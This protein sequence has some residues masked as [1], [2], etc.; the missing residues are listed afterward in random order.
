M[1]YCNHCGSNIRNAKFC[2]QC[3]KPAIV[4]TE[5]ATSV[6]A[7]IVP[8]FQW[9]SLG[10]WNWKR[11]L[12][13]IGIVVVC[14]IFYT[15]GS[16]SADPKKVVENFERAVKENN[17]ALM[18]EQLTL[19]EQIEDKSVLTE[20]VAKAILADIQSN[21]MLEMYK[22]DF[23]QSA[24]NLHDKPD[25]TLKHDKQREAA[26]LTF[27]KDGHKWLFFDNYKILISPAY[28]TLRVPNKV[29]LETK[30]KG[31]QIESMIE[32]SSE[33]QKNYII[34]PLLPGKH[35]LVARFTSDLF[36]D[37]T[38]DT[39]FEVKLRMYPD[40]PLH[41][42]TK[43]VEI[44]VD[45]NETKLYYKDKQIPVQY[46]ESWNGFRAELD[47]VPTMPISLTYK[48]V[49]P[50]GEITHEQTLGEQ[51]RLLQCPASLAEAPEFK[52]VVGDL[53]R[54]YNLAWVIYA[55]SKSNLDGLK[56]FLTPNSPTLNQYT[57]EIAQPAS[58]VFV[59][60]LTNLAIDYQSAKLKDATH[61]TVPVIET[62]DDQWKNVST[63]EISSNGSKEVFW[64]YTLELTDGKWKIS[65]NE[66]LFSWG[67]NRDQF[68]AIPLDKGSSPTSATSQS[69]SSNSQEK[70]LYQVDPAS[71]KLK[72]DSNF[73]KVAQQGKLQGIVFGLSDDFKKIDNWWG[74]PE[75]QY[76]EGTNGHYYGNIEFRETAEDSNKIADM[77]V[78]E[79]IALKKDEL[80]KI[81]GNPKDSSINDM[82]GKYEMSYPAGKNEVTFIFSDEKS[83]VSQVRLSPIK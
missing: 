40:I 34:G 45:S 21:R 47:E 46:Q 25:V 29:K 77:W 30:E 37:M 57:E 64:R 67:L 22:A 16:A 1:S 58:R 53:M 19:P 36:G 17:S 15:L 68:E 10:Q 35:T 75:V 73:L 12:P 13:V 81:F 11:I 62:Y 61:L 26:R 24:N 70:Q 32:G 74:K 52:K 79:D 33:E 59:G 38:A 7:P 71:R 60:K 14:V 44:S 72:V 31:I 42:S 50:F 63:G 80:I 20:E 18:L 83:N 76:D 66:T 78:S 27:V 28:S 54:D 8:S 3:G 56:P 48:V 69:I 65:Q 9:K 5:V 43:Q 55:Q 82:T 4:F 6:Q 41:L 39:P 2:N 23:L 51:D 49:T